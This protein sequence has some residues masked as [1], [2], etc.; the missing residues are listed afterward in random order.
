MATLGSF[1]KSTV[2][3]IA[4]CEFSDGAAVM[5]FGLDRVVRGG[6][7]AGYRWPPDTT[8]SMMVLTALVAEDVNGGENWSR[9]WREFRYFRCHGA[10]PIGFRITE[11]KHLP[12]GV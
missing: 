1:G 9:F 2:A 10:S 6:A 5:A 8:I 3:A 7:D 12:G 11:R 4:T